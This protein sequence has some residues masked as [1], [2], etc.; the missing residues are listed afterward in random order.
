M[1]RWWK[2]VAVVLLGMAV[3]PAWAVTIVKCKDSQGNI[4]F[5]SRCPPGTT[6]VQE[7]NYNTETPAPSKEAKPPL[8]VYVVPNCDSC[9][10]LKEFLAVR[11]IPVNEKNV[12]GNAQLQQQLKKLTG[13]LRVPAVVIGGKV[14]T[15]YNRDALLQALTSAGYTTKE[16]E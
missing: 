3:T 11:K 8:T 14:L 9:D 1:K 10:Q 12:A 13:A 2:P 15:G 4:T 16:A 7:K 6:Q 5:E